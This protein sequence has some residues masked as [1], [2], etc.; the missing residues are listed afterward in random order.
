MPDRD[1][2]D[3][4]VRLPE[5]RRLK[6]SCD[7]THPEE[8]TVHCPL[9]QTSRAVSE[10]RA[11]PRFERELASGGRGI[12]ECRVPAAAAV[13]SDLV[14]ELLSPEVTCLDSEVDAD[15]AVELLGI[16][17][18]TSA[19]V[20]DDNSVLVGTVSTRS[21]AQARHQSS[22]L[23]ALGYRVGPAEVEDAMSTEVVAL[24]QQATL[25]AAARLMARRNLDRVPIVTDDG[26]LV[27][28]ISAMDLVRWLAKWV[29]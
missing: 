15:R 6:V 14:G 23:Q 5:R 27:G 4:T 26:H 24:S 22:T 9:S 16:A 17:G 12:V 13:P 19:P 29:P 10:C 2:L 3:C 18:V 11:C 7:E 1:D 8:S 21:L 28:V 20:L 25:G